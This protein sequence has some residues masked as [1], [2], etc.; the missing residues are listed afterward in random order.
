MSAMDRIKD[1][2]RY[3]SDLASDRSVTMAE[4]SGETLRYLLACSD[5]RDVLRESK[6]LG[7]DAPI[8]LSTRFADA[9]R[10]KSDPEACP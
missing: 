4:V 5:M 8:S 2:I 9:E 6:R 3:L 1:E 7:E 10:R